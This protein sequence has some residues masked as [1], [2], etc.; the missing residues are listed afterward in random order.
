[1][2]G[3]GLDTVT[4]VNSTAG[5]NVDLRILVA[6]DTGGEGID[7]LS[8]FE[9][10]TGSAFGDT[11]RGTD[12]FNLIIDTGV[13]A[14]ATALSQTDSLFGY[15]GN[16]SILVT[17]AAAAV[18][19]NINLDGGDGD[20]FIEVRSGT[21]N[22]TL[23][24]NTS[25]LIGQTYAP[26]GATSNDRNLDV[27]TVDGGAGNDRII[28]TGVASATVNAGSG[29]DTVSIS[30]RGVTTVNNYVITLGAGAD[31]IQLGGT[32]A[33]V[34]TTARTNTVTDFDRGIPAIS[35]R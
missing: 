16:D 4:Y 30:M 5:V 19:T 20:D 14:G 11:L 23:A 6:Q 9:H 32:S 22:G 34:A 18:A 12:D 31:I 2:G 8:G 29:A 13:G 35:S 17:R 25:G 26:L 21:L 10:L 3:D 1:M 15:A 28:L 24:T 7:T 27:V 33:E